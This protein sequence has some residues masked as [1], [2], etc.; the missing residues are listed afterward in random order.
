MLEMGV[1]ILLE[2]ME[3]CEFDELTTEKEKAAF[4]AQFLADNK[5]LVW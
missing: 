5:D 3:L 4:L 1:K 2:K